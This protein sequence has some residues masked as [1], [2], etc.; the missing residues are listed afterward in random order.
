MKR[1]VLIEIETDESGEQ[2]ALL[3]KNRFDYVFCPFGFGRDTCRAAEVVIDEQ[4]VELAKKVVEVCE[5]FP[6]GDNLGDAWKYAD[7]LAWFCLRV[8]RAAGVIDG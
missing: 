8:A 1:Y 4:T 6:D 3:C 7:K 2:C 5:G